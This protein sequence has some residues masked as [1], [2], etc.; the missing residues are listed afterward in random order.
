MILLACS[1]HDF[2]MLQPVPVPLF[3]LQSLHRLFFPFRWRRRRS[4]ARN[5]DDDDEVDRFSSLRSPAV[6]STPY[7]Q[8]GLSPPS[9]LRVRSPAARVRVQNKGDPDSK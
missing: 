7:A 6:A 1:E 9:I 8:S 4:P 3:P 2:V 5:S